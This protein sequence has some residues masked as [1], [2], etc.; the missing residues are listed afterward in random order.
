MNLIEK[1]KEVIENLPN[2]IKLDEYFYK[3]SYPIPLKVT[4]FIGQIGWRDEKLSILDV[5]YLWF[6]K[7]YNSVYYSKDSKREANKNLIFNFL[8][9]P[10]QMFE[11]KISELIQKAKNWK[12]HNITD[13]EFAT[14]LDNFCKKQKGINIRT[15]S[16]ILRILYPIKFGTI[17]VR[18]TQALKKLDFKL[19]VLTFDD[20]TNYNGEEYLEYIKLLECIGEKYTIIYEGSK[21]KM[22]PGEVDMALYTFD[23]IRK[24]SKVAN[25][26]T[27]FKLNSGI[28]QVDSQGIKNIDELNKKFTHQMIV[29]IELNLLELVEEEFPKDPKPSKDE[30][31]RIIYSVKTLRGKINNFKHASDFLGLFDYIV[32]LSS[33]RDPTLYGVKVRNILKHYGYPTIE[34]LKR[35]YLDRLYNQYCHARNKLED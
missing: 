18:A 13:R 4:Y 28:F 31:K 15:L 33:Q 29:G 17:D 32:Y 1:N 23:K 5:F 30:K 3:F 2:K 7:I 26:E 21:R 9:Q 27:R 20:G 22:Y 8:M 10:Q 6:Q 12:N 11:S 35:K 16:F 34:F 24:K 14:Y 25:N 19:K